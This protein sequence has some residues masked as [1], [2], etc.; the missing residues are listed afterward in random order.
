MYIYV[1]IYIYVEYIYIC[2]IYI[3][4]YIYVEYIYIC[5]YNI[6]TSSLQRLTFGIWA[7]NGLCNHL[8]ALDAL[9]SGYC[10]GWSQLMAV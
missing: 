4:I 10:D 9:D 6:Y 3:C 5:M 7:A 8:D 2:I 1:Y